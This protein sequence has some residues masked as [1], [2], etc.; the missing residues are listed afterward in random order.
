LLD[1]ALAVI[2]PFDITDMPEAEEHCSEDS[3]AS[4]CKEGEF[5]H[6]ASAISWTSVAPY[7]SPIISGA[8]RG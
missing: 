5:I 8:Y 3:T 6:A 7:R 2:V 4:A 1:D